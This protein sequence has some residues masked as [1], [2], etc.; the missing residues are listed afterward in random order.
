MIHT[1]LILSFFGTC[2]SQYASAPAYQDQRQYYERPPQDYQEET[3]SKRPPQIVSH[4]QA[5]SHDGNFKYAFASENG[6]LQ[7]ESIAP[8][9]SRTGAYEYVDPHGKKI[10]VKYIAGKEGFKI[11]EGAHIPRPPPHPQAQPHPGYGG[12]GPQPPA[13]VQPY[14]QPSPLPPPPPPPRQ[15]YPNER[16]F[17]PQQLPKPVYNV[18]YQPQQPPRYYG[19]E[20]RENEIFSDAQGAY[21][22]KNKDEEYPDVEPG[23]PHSFGVG[24]AFEF[25]KS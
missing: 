7:G 17:Y 14:R 13:Q 3:N 6:H 20:R 2:W 9:G 16:L 22:P 8:D 1:V 11:L 4:K 24:Y 10:L 5:L 18:K 23:K 21:R 19:P 25:G 12:P 15:Q